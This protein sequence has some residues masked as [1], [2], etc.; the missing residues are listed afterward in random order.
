MF[1]GAGG[2]RKGAVL[3]GSS[4]RAGGQGVPGRQRGRACIPAAPAARSRRGPV[5]CG[6]KQACKTSVAAL[7]GLAGLV[8]TAPAIVAERTREGLKRSQSE[9]TR[10]RPAVTLF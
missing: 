9:T 1:G 2:A 7:A 3:A 10:E 6:P 5:A 8:A 4:P